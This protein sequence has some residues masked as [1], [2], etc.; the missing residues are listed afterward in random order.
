MWHFDSEVPWDR[1]HLF[2][3]Y[4]SGVG[5]RHATK[6]WKDSVVLTERW[7]LLNGSELY[8][9]QAD[10]VQR[11]DV[12]SEYPGVNPTLLC[13]QDWYLPIARCYLV[14]TFP[15]RNMSIPTSLIT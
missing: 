3:Q 14:M 11:K 12:S 7:R 1:K 9:I 10:P 8:D 5:F 6:E 2:I 15:T 13:S 4:Q